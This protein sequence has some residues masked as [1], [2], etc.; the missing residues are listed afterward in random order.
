MKLIIVSIIWAAIAVFAGYQAYHFGF[1]RGVIAGAHSSEPVV[2]R[3]PLTADYAVPVEKIE[4]LKKNDPIAYHVLYEDGTERRRSSPLD[5]EWRAGT[6]VDKVTG[7]VVFRSE[8]KYD[9]GT[10]WP[11]FYQPVNSF[12][13]TE[14]EDNSSWFGPRTEIRSADG[15]RHYGHVFNDGPDPTGLRYCMNGAA[16][17][18]I[19]DE[20]Q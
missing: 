12:A 6:Y 1:G 11:S 3:K 2:K 16:L 18:F 4:A 14:H 20:E 13:V 5:K 17:T 7:E 8:H 15:K 10:G 9:S 19:P